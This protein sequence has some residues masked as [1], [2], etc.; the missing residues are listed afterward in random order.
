MKTKIILTISVWT[1]L[2]ILL[3]IAFGCGS[4]STTVKEN[5]K[6]VE[7]TTTK[8]TVRIED[9]KIQVP[10]IN[11][12]MEVPFD[13]LTTDVTDNGDTLTIKVTKKGD[14]L[15]H[16]HIKVK[17][18]PVNYRDT[19]S[20]SNSVTNS[21]THTDINSKT[22]TQT[23]WD[24]VKGYFSTTVLIIIAIILAVL[25]VAYK[26]RSILTKLP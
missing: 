17:P 1:V 2:I 6:T 20:I 9:K 4:S 23:F 13:S 16:A 19:T 26:F 18:A 22:V 3:L 11:S 7:N 10:E 12:D 25:F 14:N 5:T 21:Q 8:E 24:K 15:I